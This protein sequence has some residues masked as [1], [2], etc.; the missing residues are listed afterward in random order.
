MGA[1]LPV[2]SRYFITRPDNLG[3]SVGLLYGVN[4]FGAVLGCCAGR[5]C[6]DSGPGRNLDDLWGRAAEPCDLRRRVETGSKSCHP[7]G[8][9]REQSEN[10]GKNQKPH[11]KNTH[12]TQ[13]K[14]QQNQSGE[15]V[16]PAIRPAVVW[17]VMAGIGISG[18]AA[19]IYQIAWTRVISLSIG[20]SVY[21]FSLIVTAFICGLALGSLIISKFID[22]RRNLVLWLALVQG[23]I[24]ISALLIVPL[25]GKL[26]VF[27]AQSVFTASHTFQYIHFAEFAIIFALILVPTLMMGA[28]VPMAIKI[29]TPDAR[30]VARFFGNVYAVNTLGAIFGSFM[31]GF[32]LIPWLGTQKSILVAVALNISTAVIMF[33]H[34]PQVSAH[35][36]IAAALA[37]AGTAALVW[38]PLPQWNAAVLTSGPF[39]YAD[40][41]RSTSAQKGIDLGS[42]MQAG[43]QLL[44]FKEGLHALVSVEKTIYGDVALGVNGKIDAS[45]KGGTR[46]PS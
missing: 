40:E 18:L 36:R 20:A 35:R 27:V 45:A 25:L 43:K 30:Q 5:I 6:P 39:L 38:F 16:I 32:C 37:T 1:T 24:G 7:R 11:Q 22:G 8:D 33:L 29:C 4:T 23:A 46:Q 26:P 44:Y 15:E 14:Q 12:K 13:H 9:L 42:A 17:V 41:Y 19:M 34:T 2:L 21:A 28:A 10:Q 31:A 3:R